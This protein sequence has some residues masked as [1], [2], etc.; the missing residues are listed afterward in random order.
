M[1]SAALQVP[2]SWLKIILYMFDVYLNQKNNKS[3][4]FIY[5]ASPTV[6][7]VR[8]PRSIMAMEK[9]PRHQGRS[10]AKHEAD[11]TEIAHGKKMPKGNGR[12][13]RCCACHAGSCG[14][15]L[16]MTD[17]SSDSSE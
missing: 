14:Q 16:A 11:E 13:L 2:G 3:E 17:A 6:V 5:K 10:I 9:V 4:H 1:A 12:Q 15:A 8:V 7:Q